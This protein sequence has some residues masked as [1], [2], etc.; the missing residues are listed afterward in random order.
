MPTSVSCP[1][2][3]RL[4]DVP[5]EFAGRRFRCRECGDEVAIPSEDSSLTQAPAP[6]SP[7]EAVKP[8]EPV[9]PVA[10]VVPVG[11][12]PSRRPRPQRA[13]DAKMPSTILL[14]LV[15]SGVHMFEDLFLILSGFSIAGDA[16]QTAGPVILAGLVRLGI[17][18]GIFNGLVKRR[19]SSRV[20]SIV[21]SAAGL[22]AQLLLVITMV[23]I[24]LFG[25]TLPGVSAD[26][27]RLLSGV[28]LCCGGFGMVLRCGDIAALVPASAAEWCSEETSRR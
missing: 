8:V 21:V 26:D 11:P 18:V 9:Y 24:A 1:N 5:D 25:G 19:A 27:L 7:A 16:P 12:G 15:L 13:A 14:A 6:P 2:C 3:G 17:E 4:Y 20:A 28:L 22:G 23:W 10:P